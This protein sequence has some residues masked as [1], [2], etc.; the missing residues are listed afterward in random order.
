LYRVGVVQ[1]IDEGHSCNPDSYVKRSEVA[2]ILTRMMNPEQRLRFEM[3]SEIETEINS[4]TPITVYEEFVFAETPVGTLYLSTEVEPF[5]SK[6]AQTDDDGYTLAATGITESGEKELFSIHIGDERDDAFCVGYIKNK[7]TVYSVSVQVSDMEFDSSWT[8]EDQQLVLSL[9]ENL[10]TIVDQFY[11]MDGFSSNK[12]VEGANGQAII[13][14]DAENVANTP[15]GMIVFP[16][17]W[18]DCILI[19]EKNEEELYSAVFYDRSSGENLKLFT[20][21]VG[22]YLVDEEI[23]GYVTREGTTYSIGIHME[24]IAVQESW[25]DLDKQRVFGMQEDISTIYEQFA[26]MQGFTEKK[27]SDNSSGFE[28]VSTSTD[29]GEQLVMKT[30]IGDLHFFEGWCDCVYIEQFLD[31]GMYG[32]IVF[33]KNKEVYTKLFTVL[34]CETDSMDG[35]VGSVKNNGKLY[36]VSLIVE[37]LS[38]S[39]SWSDLDK[40]RI[41]GMQEEVNNIYQQIKELP[42]FEEIG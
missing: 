18:Y 23:I 27:P 21:Y 11:S 37:E 32:A 2:A 1:G 9:Q 30:P 38:L 5:I 31:D 17:C 4:D 28:E 19:E 36:Y 10:N 3:I 29:V 39:S 12:P 24:M 13:D 33:D 35:I 14:S 40:E 41:F 26:Q 15:V 6:K 7:T 42:G 16:E 20:V 25:D 34:V 22:D 8:E